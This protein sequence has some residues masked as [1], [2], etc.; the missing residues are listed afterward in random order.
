VAVTVNQPSVLS[1]VCMIAAV[2]G[3]LMWNLLPLSSLLLKQQTQN[4][5]YLWHQTVAFHSKNFSYTVPSLYVH[6]IHYF[7][8]LL[9]WLH[10]ADWNTIPG[11]VGK[12]YYPVSKAKKHCLE[13]HKKIK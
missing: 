12:C 3:Q 7:A 4:L 13:P 10:R 11:G 1:F 9:C 8:P 2:A 5:S 6:S